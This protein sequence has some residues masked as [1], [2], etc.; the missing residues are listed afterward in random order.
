M[1]SVK[2]L[3]PNVNTKSLMSKESDDAK[4]RWERGEVVGLGKNETYAIQ[5]EK[6]GKKESGKKLRD[7]NIFQGHSRLKDS[8]ATAV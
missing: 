4:N 1:H 8:K 6:D 7:I 5:F 3:R 2:K